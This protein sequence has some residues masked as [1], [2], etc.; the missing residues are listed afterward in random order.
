ME[1]TF[2]SKLHIEKLVAD[3][4]NWVTYRDHMIW[5]LRSRQLL[6]HLNSATI[7]AT[8][9]NAGDVNNQ[10]PATRWANN[11]ATTMHII[12]SSIPN[13]V[14]TAIKGNTTAKGVWDALKALY[15]SRTAMA[16]ILTS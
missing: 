2:T 9:T 11:E 6:D 10:S 12:A 4:S 15:E 8:Y 13:S 16:I 3:G 14:F 1:D 5:S 7:T